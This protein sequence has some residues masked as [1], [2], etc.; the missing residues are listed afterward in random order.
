MTAP[1]VSRRRLLRV[2]GLGLVLTCVTY[3]PQQAFA[4]KPGKPSKERLL[5]RTREDKTEEQIAEEK[6]RIQEEKKMRLERQKELQAD[7]EKKKADTDGALDNEVEIESNLRGQYYYPTARKRYLP[8][9]K[10]AWESIT[11]CEEAVAQNMW[12]KVRTECDNDLNDAVLPMRLYASSLA[13]GGLSIS[14]KF[15]EKMNAETASFEKALKGLSVAAKQQNAPVA[16]EKLA[17]MTRAIRGYREAGRLEAPDF[18]IGD[19]PKDGRVG[20]GFGNNNSALYGRNK[21]LENDAQSSSKR[22]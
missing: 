16:L 9:V 5:Q 11:T 2:A 3:P 7:A 1:S 12:T 17:E 22:D 4:L 8:R 21:G 10:R 20:S 15:I 14:A 19:I 18:G 6:A 13:G